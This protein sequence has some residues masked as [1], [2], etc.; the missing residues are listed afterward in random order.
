MYQY[1][2][3]AQLEEIT[4]KIQGE[5]DCDWVADMDICVILGNLL[6]NAIEG[7]K[8]MGQDRRL[9]VSFQHTDTTVCILAQNT[10]DGRVNVEN[11]EMVS[12]KREHLSGVGLKSVENLCEKYRGRM[13][14][15]YDET[16][17]SV[18]LLLEKP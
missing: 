9:S 1:L 3:L 7:C 10:Y 18:N 8:T 16:L 4:V 5:L 2:E 12:R 11:G 15:C 14:I 17:F 6:D 13:D